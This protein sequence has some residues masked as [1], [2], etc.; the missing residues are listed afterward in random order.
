MAHVRLT[1]LTFLLLLPSLAYGQNLEGILNIIG[2]GPIS[3]VIDTPHSLENWGLDFH[4]PLS[5]KVDDGVEL[6][7]SYYLPAGAAT[8]PASQVYPTVIFANPWAMTANGSQFSG[9]PQALTKQ[10]YVVM[11]LT[12]RG[13]GTSTGE[14]DFAGARDRA[15]VSE[16]I[17]WLVAHAHADPTAIGTIG[18]S[19]GAGV[20]LM[21]GAYDPRI[22][23]VVAMSC[24]S[25]LQRDGLLYDY[26]I[27]DRA[28][29]FLLQFAELMHDNV[30]QA[31]QLKTWAYTDPHGPDI[32]AWSHSR[33]PA[34]ARGLIEAK[35]LPV[36]FLHTYNDSFFQP[37]RIANFYDSLNTP[38][39]ASYYAGIHGAGFLLEQAVR[40]G[41]GDETVAWFNHWLKHQ[42]PAKSDQGLYLTVRNER[43]SGDLL[44][45]RRQHVAYEKGKGTQVNFAVTPATTGVGSLSPAPVPN[46]QQT[47]S[48][49]SP[50]S[51]RWIKGEAAPTLF[52]NS[53]DFNSIGEGLLGIPQ[54]FPVEGLKSP[55]V[56]LF[57]I[58][59]PDPMLLN[60]IAHLQLNVCS[61]SDHVQMAAYLFSTSAGSQPELITQGAVIRPVDLTKPLATTLDLDFT[62]SA[63]SLEKG[64]S[65][66][67]AIESRD[68]NIYEAAVNT[69]DIGLQPEHVAGTLTLVRSP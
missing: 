3:A 4:G 55:S 67:L 68:P 39:R 1:F 10:G 58:D 69:P 14:A 56:V 36:F 25:D 64:H 34:F 20:A 52:N 11:E 31:Y 43:P 50:N 24:W 17:D 44:S 6:E 46:A 63:F 15:D 7:F 61:T 37:N 45:A 19:Y 13:F 35:Q 49:S 23:A 18:V 9:I 65:L 30:P 32:V 48:C 66:I 29:D 21:A 47:F 12:T 5:L 40:A 59:A 8:A 54:T 28:I 27:N 60:G 62:I 51:L 38:K 53:Q 26:G 42:A 57:K 2:S 22:R 16:A 41:A 33:S